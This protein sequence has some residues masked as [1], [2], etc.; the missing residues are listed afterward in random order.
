MAEKKVVPFDEFQL[1]LMYLFQKHPVNVDWGLVVKL[2]LPG[3]VTRCAY[4]VFGINDRFLSKV[5]FNH[6]F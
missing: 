2:V 6:K 5:Q 1:K 3:K 4:K